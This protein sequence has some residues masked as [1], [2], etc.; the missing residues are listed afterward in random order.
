MKVDREI[1]Y[2]R[3]D[4]I[5]R[6]LR[7]LD[8]YQKYSSDQFIASYKDVQ[9]AKFSL[10]EI[11]EAC[12]DIANHIISVKGYPKVEQYR[13]MFKTLEEED[14]L[15]KDLASRL[16]DM[17]SFRNL[18]VHRYG[19]IDDTRILGIIKD[20]LNDIKLFMKQIIEFLE[21]EKYENN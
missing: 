21:P 7:F 2:G 9:A 12:I 19:E 11:I 1:V 17:A 10:L 5:E 14:V 15:D 3:F 20:N 13:M 8:Q 18:L 16:G 4:T 6:N